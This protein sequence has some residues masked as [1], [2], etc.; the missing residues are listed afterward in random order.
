MQLLFFFNFKLGHRNT[1]MSK[2]LKTL[3][4]TYAQKNIYLL[5]HALVNGSKNMSF[6]VSDFYSLASMGDVPW[7]LSG[8]CLCSFLCNKIIL[9]VP[10]IYVI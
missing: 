4:H 10:C 9:F 6:L 3:C 7:L 5:M 2:F 8:G 1:H